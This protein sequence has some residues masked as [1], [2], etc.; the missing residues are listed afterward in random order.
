MTQQEHGCHA[1]LALLRE[2]VP[3]TEIPLRAWRS[4]LRGAGLGPVEEG[5]AGMATCVTRL[6][7]HD[8]S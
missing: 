3:G 4:G 1:F 6:R 5:M 2:A 7:P 8:A